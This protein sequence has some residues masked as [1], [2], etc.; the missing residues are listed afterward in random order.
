MRASIVTVAA[1][2]DLQAAVD[3]TPVGGVLK[4]GPGTYTV[5]TGGL[6][7]SKAI[8]IAGSGMENTII[9]PFAV[10][11]NQPVIVFES[12]DA[13]NDVIKAVHLHDFQIN[14]GAATPDNPSA[15]LAGCYG[16]SIRPSAAQVIRSV[17][18][19]RL[20]VKLMSNKGLYVTGDGG[21]SCCIGL[22]MSSCHFSQN[23]GDGRFVQGATLVYSENCLCASNYGRGSRFESC[24]P[25]IIGDY[26]EDNCHDHT[27]TAGYD[28]QLSCYS[29]VVNISGVTFE[30]FTKVTGSTYLRQESGGSGTACGLALQW[31]TGVVS[32]CKFYNA[33]QT[34]A[35]TQF[36]IH[37]DN[38]EGKAALVIHPCM[39]DNCY[40][41][42]AATTGGPAIKQTV[43]PQNAHSGD[44]LLLGVYGISIMGQPTASLGTPDVT[45]VSQIVY[46][47]TT[48]QW[49]GWDGAAWKVFQVV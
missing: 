46:D 21:A 23:W 12:G 41:A 45:A 37:V 18:L 42:I 22:R 40:I 8:E 20:N 14:G 11:A 33:A 7:I 15:V 17:F 1:G 36:G 10:S 44:S 31:V 2:A 49:K 38:T 3:L 25:T 32:A 16:I 27:L 34:A 13:L 39:F 29:G 47:T 48:N 30:D 9:S 43:F 28:G 26:Y 24:S 19:E 4:L 35:T 5:P 6:V